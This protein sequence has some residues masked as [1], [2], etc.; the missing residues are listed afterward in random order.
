MRKKE[1]DN[2]LREIKGNYE[3]ERSANGMCFI[4]PMSD[5]VYNNAWYPGR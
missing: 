5:K 2:K 1:I 4:E 3:R